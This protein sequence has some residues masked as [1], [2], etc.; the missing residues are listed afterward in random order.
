MRIYNWW[1]NEK[2][3]KRFR[4]LG[5][6]RKFYTIAQKHFALSFIDESGVRQRRD[7]GD[8]RRTIQRWCR[9]SGKHVK[10]C[11]AW[12]MTGLQKA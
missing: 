12:C 11:P 4:S 6:G 7:A 10:R 1:E 9:A 3:K 5:D 2:L 8:S